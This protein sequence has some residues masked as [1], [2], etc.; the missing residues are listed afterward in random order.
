[1]LRRL[2]FAGVIAGQLMAGGARAA[3]TASEKATAE[4]LFD[5]AVALMN[6]DDVAPAC[7][8]FEASQ[9]LDP[10][11]G[12]MLRLADCW[13]RAGRSAS[14]W[15]QFVEAEALAGKQG[16]AERRAMAAERAE[17]LKARL[18]MVVVEVKPPPPGFELRIGG[19]L[20]PKASWQTPLP[21]DPGKREIV[22][23][24]PGYRAWSGSVDV[25][26]GP[27]E[28]PVQIPALAKAPAA[29]LDRSAAPVAE[30]SG[31]TQRTL[32]YVSGGL[33]ILGLAS[34]GVLGYL[35]YRAKQDSLDY[36]STRDADLCS[37]PGVDERNRARSLGN[38]ATA[39]SIAGGALLA[40]GVILFVTA[41]SAKP[42]RT[43][44]LALNPS[45]T[46]IALDW[47]QSW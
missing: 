31:G 18:S 21:M 6:E 13:D 40:G 39:L 38:A 2:V 4:A 41:P 3:A 28:T 12:T 32:S 8:K 16:Q 30:R 10:Q 22:A 37:Q 25:P 15:A 26:K 43:A 24:A 20:I 46:S 1:M 35:A 11:L 47:S 14:A 5:Q 33:G 17:D 9:R 34:A 36:C 29:A 27:A 19:V 23:A 44:R 7:D 45:M 42:A